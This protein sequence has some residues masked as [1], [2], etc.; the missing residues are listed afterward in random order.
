MPVDNYTLT[1]EDKISFKMKGA[2][3]PLYKPST[4]YNVY[5]SPLGT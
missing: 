3:P 2:K 5:P 1:L 4:P